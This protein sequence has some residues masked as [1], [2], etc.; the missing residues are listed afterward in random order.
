M[1]SGKELDK[2][3]DTLP[4]LKE[5]EEDPFLMEED[6]LVIFK[7]L[8]CGKEDEVPD[9][10]VDEFAYGLSE[11]EEVEVVCPYCNG[12]MREARNALSD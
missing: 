5:G 12:T 11:G 6:V 7:C 2:N 1:S 4:W 9:F 3:N 8:D 10:V